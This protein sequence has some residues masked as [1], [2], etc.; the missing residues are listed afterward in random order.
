MASLTSPPGF[1]ASVQ[2]MAMRCA[3]AFSRNMILLIN[4]SSR[5][6]RQLLN[7]LDGNDA[8]FDHPDLN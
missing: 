3:G 5:E 4:S 7:L 6:I 2:A 8:A 1:A